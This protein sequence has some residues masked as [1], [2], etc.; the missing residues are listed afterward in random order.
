MLRSG[1]SLLRDSAG[2]FSAADV[3]V[4]SMLRYGMLFGIIPKEGP[5]ADYV[6]WFETLPAG[7]FRHKDH[8]FEWTRAE[9]ADW[10]AAVGSRYGY[11]VRIEPELV[12]RNVLEG[13]WTFQVVEEYDQGYY[14]DIV[15]LEQEAR[16]L[17]R[18]NDLLKRASAFFAAELDRPSR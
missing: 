18:A 8:R 16:E 6:A 1:W 14:A 13:R 2:R 11:A 10:C 4:A 17:R 7:Q 5:V 3:Y 12:G 15:R 9:F